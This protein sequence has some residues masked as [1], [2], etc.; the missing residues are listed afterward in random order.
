VAGED[1]PAGN[2]GF[3]IHVAVPGLPALHG[4]LMDHFSKRKEVTG[5]RTPVID[6]Y[7]GQPLLTFP[8]SE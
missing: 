4:L 3:L 8:A 5:F 6:D 7:A 2:D 1:S